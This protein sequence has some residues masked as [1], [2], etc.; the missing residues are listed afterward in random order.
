MNLLLAAIRTQLTDAALNAI[1]PINDIT[2]SYGYEKSNYPSI[3]LSIKEGGTGLE[4]DGVTHA[5]LKIEIYS[6]KNKLEL[7]TI[8]NLVKGL[9]HKEERAITTADRL[10]HLI[11]E[12]TVSDDEFDIRNDVWSLTA[13]Y[14]ILFSTAAATVYTIASGSIYADAT[15]VT[16]EAAHKIADFRGK[17]VLDVSFDGVFHS[18]Q[19]RF[20]KTAEYDNAIAKLII[21]E[22]TFL[23]SAYNKLWSITA[24]ADTLADDATVSTSYTISQATKPTDLQVL[25]QGT[26]TDDGKII[27]I[28]ADKAICPRIMIPIPKTDVIVY[29][30]EWICL[31]DSSDNIIKVSVED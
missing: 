7:W 23:V 11:Y 20:S 17:V 14:E 10:I 28:E 4:I 26:K 1:V 21:E 16:A 31:G 8:Y 30:S 22:V 18:G 25:W 29:D 5:T 12:V 6:K 15:D 24:T 27:E 3:V 2:S 9:L 19:N 13:E